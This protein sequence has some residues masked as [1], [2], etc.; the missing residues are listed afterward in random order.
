[1]KTGSIFGIKTVATTFLGVSTESTIAGITC[2]SW[3]A[4]AVIIICLMAG[5]GLGRYVYTLCN[6]KDS[7]IKQAS[8]DKK[9]NE[10]TL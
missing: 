5:V 8:S 2:A 4:G 10:E 1:M 9:F 7:K 6:E 3:G